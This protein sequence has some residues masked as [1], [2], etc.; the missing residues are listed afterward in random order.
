MNK[1]HL[2][3]ALL[4]TLL[5]IV[6]IIVLLYFL[7]V[8]TF[9]ANY[10]SGNWIDS[11]GSIIIIDYEGFLHES[12]VVFG[13]ES[14]DTYDTINKTA[15]MYISPLNTLNKFTAYFD[16][17]EFKIN[18]VKGTLSVVRRSDKK[19]YGE[20]YRNSLGI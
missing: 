17:Y 19:N 7:A 11:S 4:I 6:F 3:I 5:I 13:S 1:T 2:L 15:K 16:D 18:I 20:F 8:N 12:K 9:H 14:E 10:L